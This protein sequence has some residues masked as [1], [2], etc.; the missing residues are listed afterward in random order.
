[1]SVKNI[2]DTTT[3]LVHVGSN[4]PTAESGIFRSQ[5]ATSIFQAFITEPSVMKT[6]TVELYGTNDDA[7]GADSWLLL[8]SMDFGVLSK[9][10]VRI[11]APWRYFKCKV[12]NMT[13]LG[14][15][16]CVINQ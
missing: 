3:M 14:N 2:S 13:E 4:G 16:T 1:M 10:A 11:D 7:F 9:D 15:V 6:C 12:T 8:Y 5:A